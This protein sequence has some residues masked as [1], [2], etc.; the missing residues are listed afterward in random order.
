VTLSTLDYRSPRRPRRRYSR[1]T[2][3]AICAGIWGPLPFVAATLIFPNPMGHEVLATVAFLN[4]P[5]CLL[6]GM[7]L[8]SLGYALNPRQRLF[9]FVAFLVSSGQV[10]LLLAAAILQAVLS[11]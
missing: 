5:A 8:S 1:L 3:A 4:Y 2:I 6:L 7:I 11:K 9:C 10:L